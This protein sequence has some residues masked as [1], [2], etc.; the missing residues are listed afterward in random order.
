MVP[1]LLQEDRYCHITNIAEESDSL[2]LFSLFSYVD[3]TCATQSV[4]R[5][6]DNLS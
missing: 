5:I 3:C 6:K 1:F 2:A 4:G